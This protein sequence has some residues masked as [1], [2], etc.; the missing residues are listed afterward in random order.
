MLDYYWHFT[1]VPVYF[2]AVVLEKCLQ[3]CLLLAFY[4][5]VLVRSTFHGSFPKVR[6]VAGP[7]TYMDQW[8]AD[9]RRE[10]VPP[11]STKSFPV[12]VDVYWHLEKIA[13]IPTP[14]IIF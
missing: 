13:G 12:N 9:F 8:K 14:Q 2:F 4:T 10:H 5:K 11:G 6:S 3:C 7:T 1:K